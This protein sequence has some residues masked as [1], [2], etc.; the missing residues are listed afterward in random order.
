MKNKRE[1]TDH[2]WLEIAIGVIIGFVIWAVLTNIVMIFTGS[3]DWDVILLGIGLP[4]AIT[5]QYVMHKFT[6]FP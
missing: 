5:G 3:L 2:N 1:R 4:S 6:I